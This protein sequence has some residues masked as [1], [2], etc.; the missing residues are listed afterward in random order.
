LTLTLRSP[1]WAVVQ[2]IIVHYHLR[3]GGIRRVIELATPHL[4]RAARPTLTRVVLATGGAAD[5]VWRQQFDRQLPGVTVNHAVEPAFN[6]LSEQNVSSPSIARRIR[7][8]LERIFAGA[9][10]GNTVVWAHNLGVGRNPILARE[11]AAACARLQLPL[12]SHHHD[13]WFD[14]RWV[15]WPEMRRYGFRTLASSAQTVFP[16]VG[17]QLHA[18]INHADATILSRHLGKPALWLPNLSEKPPAPPRAR[19]QAARHWL[20]K[21]LAHHDA[22]VWLLPC[23]TL[24]RKNIAEALLL[25]RWLRPEAWLVVTGAASSAEEQPYFQSLEQA[26]CHHHWRLRLG[27]LAGDESRKPAVPELLAASEAVL[28]T[29]IQEGFGLPYLEAAAAQKP[30]I[31]RRL[32]NIAPDLHQFGFRFPQAYDEILIAPGLF[33][34]L[35]E[36]RR[37]EKNFRAW[38]ASLPA[39]IRVLAP[40][41]QLLASSSPAPVPFSR[42]TLTAQLEVL[43]RS[44]HES[45]TRCAPLNPFLIRWQKRAAAGRLQVTRWPR[46]AR[47]WLGG[48]AYGKKFF[49]ALAATQNHRPANFDP[50]QLQA[51]FIRSKLE[52]RNLYPLLWNRQP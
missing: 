4:L 9:D 13:W 32:S 27:I 47:R 29:S 37:Q 38:L 34:W 7:I 43:S 1:N 51:D 22:P 21:R 11:L 2:L 35:A 10:A 20:K 26:A 30:L 49:A 5:T 28:L 39:T 41:P 44:T 48:A 8:A 46:S 23:R 6:Y 19:Q 52:V 25:T 16:S 3:P 33:D 50:A 12:V 36:R 31:A 15:R 24:R 45:W 18:A 17:N 40:R 14:N 42:L